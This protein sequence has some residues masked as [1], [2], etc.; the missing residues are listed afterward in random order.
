MIL[1]GYCMGTRWCSQW[2]NAIII[3]FTTFI[4]I[5]FGEWEDQ[6]VTTYPWH[7][8]LLLHWWFSKL[9]PLTRFQF[10]VIWLV[11]LVHHRGSIKGDWYSKLFTVLFLDLKRRPLHAIH[12]ILKRHLLEIELLLS[13]SGIEILLLLLG[14]LLV[15]PYHDHLICR[16]FCWFRELLR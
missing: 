15:W 5:I 16:C 7:D 13:K 9:L 14:W 2:I 6:G 4:S 11:C 3:I 12:T 8:A 1:N 10:N